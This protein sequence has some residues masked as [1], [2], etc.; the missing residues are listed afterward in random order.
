LLFEIC[1]DVFDETVRA[2]FYPQKPDL[3]AKVA[4]EIDAND[5]CE[6]VQL[7]QR[8]NLAGGV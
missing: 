1:L 2:D 8:Q 6:I 4:S 5:G 3:V 7:L